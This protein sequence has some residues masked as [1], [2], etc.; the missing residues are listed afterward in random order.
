[1]TLLAPL[2][3]PPLKKPLKVELLFLTLGLT[4]AYESN[5]LAVWWFIGLIGVA[6]PGWARGET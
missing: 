4:T 5:K 3:M 1:M 6:Y 2:L